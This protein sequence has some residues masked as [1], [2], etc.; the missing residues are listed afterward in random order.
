VAGI[1][2]YRR[3]SEVPDILNRNGCLSRFSVVVKNNEDSQCDRGRSYL[4]SF[5][6]FPRLI[7][8]IRNG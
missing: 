6:I 7:S 3:Y 8:L 2:F 1:R 4:L 5:D